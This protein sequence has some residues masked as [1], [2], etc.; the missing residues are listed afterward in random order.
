MSTQFEKKPGCIQAALDIIG[1]KWTA[2]IIRDLY[3][4]SKR[5][6]QL[7][8]S[9]PGI[10]PRTLSQRLSKLEA[11]QVVEKQHSSDVY[12][13]PEY[14]LTPKGSDF[15]GILQQMADWGAKYHSET[16]V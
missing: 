16:S 7:Q 13:Y 15:A 6:N 9:L 5:F 12:G 1:E 2:L 10:S 11:C 3:Y 8:N 4:G 14:T